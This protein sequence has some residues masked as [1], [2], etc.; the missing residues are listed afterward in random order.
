[1]VAAGGDGGVAHFVWWVFVLISYI[2]V[3]TQVVVIARC[4]TF[5]LLHSF[6]YLSSYIFKFRM[7]PNGKKSNALRAEILGPCGGNL[8]EEIFP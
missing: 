8:K 5:T 1:M 6:L 4:G 7:L 2:L 3:T